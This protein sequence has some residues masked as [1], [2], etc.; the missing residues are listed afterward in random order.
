MT[1]FVVSP[2]AAPLLGVARVPGDKSIGHRALLLGAIASG[3]TV[4]RGLSGGGD[5]RST[6]RAIEAMG[7]AVEDRP[8]GSVAVLGRGLRGLRAANRPLDCGNSGTTMRLLCGLLCGQRFDSILCG[9]KSL[10][11]RPMRRVIDPLSAMGA[12]IGGTQRGSNLVP[13][14]SIRG[15]EGLRGGHFVQPIASAQVKSAILLAALYAEGTTAVVE[16]GASRDHTERMLA[17]MGAPIAVAGPEITLNPAAWSGELVGGS[18]RV[19]GDPS[20]AAFLVAAGLL[21][22]VERLAVTDVCTNPRRTG[23]LDVLAELGALVEW[24]ARRE[25][26]GEPTAD[27]VLSRGAGE[28]MRGTE[29]AGDLTVRSID[30]L[31]I[32]AVVAARASGESTFRDAAELRVKESDRIAATCA[33][34]RTFGAEVEERDDGFVV[35]GLAGRPFRA[36]RI[37]AAGD[38]RIAMAAAVAALA[39][40]GKVRIDSAENVATSFPRFAE[41]M[42]GIGAEISVEP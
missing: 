1:A 27:L 29:V 41:A 23:F 13:P 18:R 17:A 15:R 37:D 34:L 31:P 42:A 11:A 38:H 25:G 9:D 7:I 2:A 24:E 35:E 6:R 4:I 20:A 36:G 30:E 40:D 19:P 21:A 8:D 12:E 28:G 16:P 39:A 33:M 26:S 10:S 3:E 22:G 32:L 5:N 14:L